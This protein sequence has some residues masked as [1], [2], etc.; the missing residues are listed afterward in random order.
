M[1]FDEYQQ[2]AARTSGESSDIVNGALGLAGEAGEVVELIKKH[3]YHGRDLDLDA[4]KKELGD[5]LWYMAETASQAGLSLDDIAA[6]NVAK[7]KERHPD[8]FDP[9]YH[10]SADV[11]A[12]Y[13]WR[14]DGCY[15][16]PGSS[17]GDHSAHIDYGG[18]WVVYAAPDSG[19]VVAKG[20]APGEDGKRCAEAALRRHLEAKQ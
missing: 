5:L 7:L 19:S 14:G 18:G 3:R 11:L 1:I 16:A 15:H 10:G 12:G 2:L 13:E 8:G 9:S 4:L 20:D 17:E 6:H